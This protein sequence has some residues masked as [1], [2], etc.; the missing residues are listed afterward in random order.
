MDR[1]WGVLF[2]WNK[3]TFYKLKIEILN[4][5][6]QKCQVQSKVRIRGQS[7]NTKTTHVEV[8]PS[9]GLLKHPLQI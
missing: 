8:K 2:S 4:L 3:V 5:S 1:P 9:R 6:V 7:H